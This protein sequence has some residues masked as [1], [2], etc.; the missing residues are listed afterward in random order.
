M[1]FTQII[2]LHSALKPPWEGV[3]GLILSL[4]IWIFRIVWLNS[5]FR[6][7]LQNGNTTIMQLITILIPVYNEEANLT[8]LHSELSS[9]CARRLQINVDGRCE[10]VDMTA[11]E[12]E[13]LFVNDGSS[14]R[15]Q[16]ILTSLRERDAR[17]NVLNFSRN[18]G[19]ET[20]LLAG[21]DFSRGDAL[22]IMDADLQHP[23]AVIPE[24]IYWWQ[25]GFDDVYGVRSS[26]DKDPVI[27]RLFSKTFYKILQKFSRVDI[28]SN[29]GDFRLLSRRAV[30]ALISMRESQRYTKGLYCWV[31]F[32]KRPVSFEVAERREGK[33]SF[34]YSRL[35]NLAIDGITSYTTS[36]LRIASVTGILVSI[37]SMIYLVFVICKFFLY[38]EPVQGYPTLVCLILFI[39]GVQ[40]LAL[41][42]I[43]E[44][45]GR[46]FTETKRRP[47]YII[48]S[49][50]N[51]SVIQRADASQPQP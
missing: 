38:G 32:N 26:R 23:V 20:A 16:D 8:K 33:S 9:L 30:D 14:D 11:F 28:L 18:F 50:N 45:I 48:E 1:L 51:R 19:K 37:L 12:W 43:G 25:H 21:L 2:I 40:L 46:I 3:V 41:G 13:Y 31:G 49:F 4:I 29:A 5:Q 10:E 6:R 27:R 42:I 15:S 34:T 39:G 17:V 36:P 44:Y 7:L 22:I 24:M 47:P 35:F